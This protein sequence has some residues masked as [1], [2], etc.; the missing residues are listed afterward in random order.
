MTDKELLLA[1][2]LLDLAQE[3]FSNHGCNDL[4]KDFL[5]DWAL[6]EKK[7]LMKDYLELNGDP[8]NY[9]DNFLYFMDDSLMWLMA[10]KIRDMV[11]PIKN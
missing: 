6:E 9:D 11:N 1:A 7:Q 5:E 2:K 4:P 10:E 3:E 8:E